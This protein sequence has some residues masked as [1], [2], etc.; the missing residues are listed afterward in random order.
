MKTIQQEPQ[1]IIDIAVKKI[2][3]NK[4]VIITIIAVLLVAVCVFSV[5]KQQQNK[6]YQEEWG[7]MFLAELSLVTEKDNSVAALEDFASKYKNTPAGAY[8]AMTMGNAY[9][10]MDDFPKA[11]TYFKQALSEGN[12]DIAA[13]AETSLI[14]VQISQK[15][16]DAAIAQAEAFAA[17]NPTHFALAQVN[18]YKALAQELS[19]KKDEAKAEYKKIT[20]EYPNTYYAAFA[21][22]RLKQL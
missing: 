3:A 20:Q 10:Q 7:N 4:N 17:K 13:L 5:Y 16:Y 18:Q 8:A 22:L 1:G 9:Y 15:M 11:E 6:K 12:K 14:A 2:K 19:G 21:E